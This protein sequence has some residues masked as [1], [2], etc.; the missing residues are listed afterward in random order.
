MLL[1]VPIQRAGQL[2]QLL[3]RRVTDRWRQRRHG[4][5]GSNLCGCRPVLSLLLLLLL[6]LRA[7]EAGRCKGKV[8][9]VAA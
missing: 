8:L 5:F 9:T 6:K 2:L 4:I 7:A 3:I 1:H